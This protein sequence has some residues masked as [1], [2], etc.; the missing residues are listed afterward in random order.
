MFMF[1][2][3]VISRMITETHRDI[4]MF[5]GDNKHPFEQRVREEVRK[6]GSNRLQ[7]KTDMEELSAKRANLLF[8]VCMSCVIFFF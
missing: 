7:V 2:F 3:F 4:K 6:H 5:K 1:L 8:A